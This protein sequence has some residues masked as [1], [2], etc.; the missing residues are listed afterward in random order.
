MPETAP[1]VEQHMTGT[2]TPWRDESL[3]HEL[4][5]EEYLSTNQIA[6][7][8]GCHQRTVWKWMDRFDIPRRSTYEAAT[9]RR[10]HPVFTDRGYVICA[11]NYSGTNDSV[12][13][14]RLVMV[15]EHGFDAVAGKQ[16]PSTKSR[17]RSKRKQNER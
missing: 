12:G 16:P 8:F 2:E 9:N 5:W 14:H 3:L 17:Q 10:L 6:D 7:R 4:Y 11:S 1:T 15:A 13:I